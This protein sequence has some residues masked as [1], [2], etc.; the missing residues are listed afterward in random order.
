[1]TDEIG[2]HHGLCKKEA[3]S[4]CIYTVYTI[5]YFWHPSYIG[6]STKIN[7]FYQSWVKRFWFYVYSDFG[8]WLDNKNTTFPKLIL[9]VWFFILIHHLSIQKAPLSQLGCKRRWM[10]ANWNFVGVL[11]HIEIK[12]QCSFLL[13]TKHCGFWK[14]DNICSSNSFWMGSR[15][16]LN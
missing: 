7:V 1:M 11:Y 3:A 15:G 8:F 16:I 5:V 12:C 2:Y 9:I 10:E 13:E 4:V 14:E 6:N